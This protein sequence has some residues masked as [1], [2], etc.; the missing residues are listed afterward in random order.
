MTYHGVKFVTKFV[1]R[2]VPKDSRIQE[3]K[4]WCKE[5][6]EHGLA[7]PYDGGSYGNLSFRVNGDS[8]II[9][10]SKIGMKDELDDSCFVLV[11]SVENGIVHA[12]GAR[13]PSSESMLHAAIYQKRK[14]VNAIFHGHCREIVERAGELGISE[15]SKEEPYGTE[16]LVNS[17]LELLDDNTNF[18]VMKNHGF[19]SLGSS[20]ED[21]GKLA[22]EI[23]QRENIMKQLKFSEP[24]P[25]LILEGKKDTTW[26]IGDKRMI[27]KGD[28]ISLCYNNGTEFAQAKVLWVKETTFE[29]LKDE[30]K[31]GHEKFSSNS[32]MYKTYSNYYN[33]EVTPR[34]KVNVIKFTL[35]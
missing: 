16:E 29:N 23:L 33:M 7:P 32:E 11:S 2:K 18:I 19:I 25:K 21:A 6:H 1:G 3:L 9:T 13:G 14:D 5:F 12:N 8:F 10:G 27:T 34:T 35:Q 15:T 17:V 26:R 28:D 30:D 31:E 22:L 24:L 4:K 20:M